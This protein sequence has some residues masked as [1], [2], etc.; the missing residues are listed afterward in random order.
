MTLGKIGSVVLKAKSLYIGSALSNFME[1]KLRFGLVLGRFAERLW[2][3]F[4]S[5][6]H[7]FMD[8]NNFELFLITLQCPLDLA[9]A[10]KSCIIPYFYVK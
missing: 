1:Q 4:G 10:L 5:F 3:T 9:S 7:V 6:F 2:V 8:K